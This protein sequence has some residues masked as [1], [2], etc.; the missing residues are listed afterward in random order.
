VEQA[1]F[2]TPF[3]GFFWPARAQRLPSGPKYSRAQPLEDER[4]DSTFEMGKA[5]QNCKKL[6]KNGKFV[7]YAT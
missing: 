5:P 7:F 4:I 1:G 2:G 6:S 3:F